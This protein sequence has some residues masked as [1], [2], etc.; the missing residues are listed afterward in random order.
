MEMFILNIMT[1]LKYMDMFSTLNF[2]ALQNQWSRFE[3][4][5]LKHIRAIN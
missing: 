2:F 5:Y 4:H 1:N 3:Q